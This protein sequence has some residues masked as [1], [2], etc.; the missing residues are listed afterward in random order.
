MSKAALNGEP[1]PVSKLT[2]N[3]E[4]H[5]MCKAAPNGER[6]PCNNPPESALAAA[7]VLVE[8]SERSQNGKACC[9]AG[10]QS[11]RRGHTHRDDPL[12]R[13]TGANA[14]ALTLLRPAL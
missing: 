1:R 3:G 14:A 7:P 2:P 13:R 5:P 11:H 12:T 10:R 8:D 6:D 9:Q 4:P